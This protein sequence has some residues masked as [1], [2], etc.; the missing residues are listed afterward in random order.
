MNL[1]IPN[2]LMHLPLPCEHLT[3]TK[4]MATGG[5]PLYWVVVDMAMEAMWTGVGSSH[6]NYHDGEFI[7]VST[8]T[9]A[10]DPTVVDT[11]SG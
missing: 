6:Q 3:V 9:E 5:N 10:L 7:W 8:C 11:L 4:H 2:F 1:L